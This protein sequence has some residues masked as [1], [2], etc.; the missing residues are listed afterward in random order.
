M[1]WLNRFQS[2]DKPDAQQ[3]R[4][5]D[6]QWLQDKFD[7]S[8]SRFSWPDISSGST[9]PAKRRTPNAFFMQPLF[10]SPQLA[11]IIGSTPMPRTEVVSKLWAYIKQNKLQDNANKR[12]VN[13]DAKLRA[14]FGKSQVSMFEMAGLIGK[15]VR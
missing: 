3:R 13:T 9:R 1:L 11:A 2:A 12:M 14:V 15:H 4:L 6:L 10:P 8:R 7:P 5:E